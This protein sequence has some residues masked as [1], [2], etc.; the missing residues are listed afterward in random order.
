MRVIATVIKTTLKRNAG[1]IY[2]LA[3][4][5]AV[6]VAKWFKALGCGPVIVGSNPIV[7]LRWLGDK[8]G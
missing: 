1:Y 2:T 8:N 4:Q 5:Q 6:S 3:N 7:H